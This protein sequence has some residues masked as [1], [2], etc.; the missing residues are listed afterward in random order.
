MT[1]SEGGFHP[2]YE[3]A[4]LEAG[5]LQSENGAGAGLGAGDEGGEV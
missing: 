2:P 4:G 1:A 3:G 5:G